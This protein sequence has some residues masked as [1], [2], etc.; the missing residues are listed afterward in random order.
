MSFLQVQKKLNKGIDIMCVRVSVRACVRA[1][2][3]LSVMSDSFE[4]LWTIACQAPLSME[5]SREEYWSEL[6]SPSPGELP[7]PGSNLGLLHCRQIIY[8]LSYQGIL[9]TT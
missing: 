3:S 5:F 7:D 8:H 2:V 1:C 6:P 9:L 4:T